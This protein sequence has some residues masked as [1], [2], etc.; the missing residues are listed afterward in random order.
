[1]RS[2][3]GD[4]R[5]SLFTRV[6]ACFNVIFISIR[7]SF[8]AFS[9][10]WRRRWSSGEVEGH[11]VWASR[12]MADPSIMVSDRLG[13]NRTTTHRV[14]GQVWQATRTLLYFIPPGLLALSRLLRGGGDQWGNDSC[15]WLFFR[16]CEHHIWPSSW[17]WQPGTDWLHRWW[18]QSWVGATL[19]KPLWCSFYLVNHETAELYNCWVFIFLTLWWRLYSFCFASMSDLCASNLQEVPCFVRIWAYPFPRFIELKY[20][21]PL[22]K[23][24][25]NWRVLMLPCHIGYSCLT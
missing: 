6:R 24:H 25:S 5:F 3:G 8:I 21:S 18:C 1:M 10:F 14:G 7:M 15:A 11:C 13:A 19:G 16:P 4:S 9:I 22:K 2:A 23:L 12:G 17:Q 20:V